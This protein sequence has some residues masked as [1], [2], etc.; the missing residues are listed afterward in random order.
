MSEKIGIEL[1]DFGSSLPKNIIYGEEDKEIVKE[2]IKEIMDNF[3]SL[4]MTKCRESD[5]K[6]LSHCNVCGKER[7]DHE[8]K[9]ELFDPKGNPEFKGKSIED[10]KEVL[11][12]KY[13]PAIWICKECMDNMVTIQFAYPENPVQS[14][15]T[16]E[17]ISDE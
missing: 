1:P 8:G 4:I 12:F 5:V 11:L 14:L 6:S 10:G 9:V 17:E 16:S 3:I 7:Q 13:V 15:A 2:T